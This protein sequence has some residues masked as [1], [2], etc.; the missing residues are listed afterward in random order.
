MNHDRDS[1]GRFTK[2]NAFAAQGGRARADALTQRR[3]K[4]IARKARRAMVRK[5]F[6]GDDHAQRRYL[7]QLGR[8][9]YEVMAGVTGGLGL[10]VRRATAHPGPIQD[11]RARYYTEDLFTGAHRDVNFYQGAA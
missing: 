6:G 5:H 8:Y 7:G 3:R 9:N 10:S 11:W 2:G 4:A 1:Q